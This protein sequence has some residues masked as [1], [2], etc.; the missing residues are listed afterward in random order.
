MSSIALYPGTRFVWNGMP[1]KLVNKLPG[2]KLTVEDISSGQKLEIS[3]SALLKAFCCREIRFEVIGNGAK[4][5]PNESFATRD[6]YVDMQDMP[7]RDFEIAKYRRMIISPLLQGVRTGN[8]GARELIKQRV[9]EITA[10]ADATNEP[11]D[12][13]KRRIS[14]SRIYAW[15]RLYNNSGANLRSLMP[16]HRKRG[17]VGKNRTGEIIDNLINLAIE[18]IYF[19]HREKTTIDDVYDELARSIAEENSLSPSNDPLILPSRATVARRL[20]NTDYERRFAAKHGKRLARMETQKYGKIEKPKFPLDRI[21]IDSTRGDLIVVDDDYLPLGRPTYTIAIDVFT[22]YI[23]GISI[24]FEPPST[25]T[26]MECLRH[27]IMPKNEDEMIAYGL[28]HPWEAYGVP[29]VL[30]CDNGKEFVGKDLEY[31]CYDLH[32]DLQF[33]PVKMP[34]CKPYIE[35]A[36][37]TLGQ[38]LHTLPGTTYS[39]IFEKKSNDYDAVHFSC[40]KY[41]DLKRVM[42]K[43][44]VDIY[45][46]DYHR[47]LNA[48][49]AKVWQAAIDEGFMPSLPVSAEALDIVLCRNADRVLMH[50]GIEFEAL[51]Y[52]SDELNDLR[53]RMNGGGRVKVKYD[54][55]DVSFVYV[56]DEN[57]DVHIKVPALD[58]EYVKGLSLWKHRVVRR[59][60]RNVLGKVDHASLGKAKAEVRDIVRAAMQNKK[61]TLRTQAARFKFGGKDNSE[62]NN[63]P[64]STPVIDVDSKKLNDV[65]RS[66]NVTDEELLAIDPSETNGWANSGS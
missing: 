23:L 62:E 60:C 39:N 30:V 37:G 38:Y 11:K 10:L 56:Y 27:S 57:N 54:P 31:A 35:R 2:R 59:Y 36:I 32:I 42:T 43:F 53:N 40:V 4:S 7:E 66:I 16:D 63:V 55:N 50:Y 44:L 41:S 49:P 61:L 12:S 9:L 15:V 6:I 20:N 46:Q 64:E 8:K 29:R 33:C 28:T 48:I 5:A 17:G 65:V 47:G 34:Y 51:I 45:A 18:K 1:Y 26:V 13:Y 21:E 24:S 58:T 52:N 3:R 14:I 19:A 22:R 25:L